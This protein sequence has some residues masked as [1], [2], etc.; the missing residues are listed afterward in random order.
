MPRRFLLLLLFCVGLAE[1]CFAQGNFI[2]SFHSFW[3]AAKSDSTAL[4]WLGSDEL[5][6]SRDSF[7]VKPGQVR[8]SLSMSQVLDPVQAKWNGQPLQQWLDYELDRARG[9]VVLLRPREGEGTLIVEYHFDPVAAPPRVQLHPMK[10]QAELQELAKEGT[11]P[12]AGGNSIEQTEELG[13]ASS[14][15]LSVSGSKTVSV[16]GGTNRDATV[17]QGL[18]LAV[19]GKLTENTFVRAQISDENLPITPEGNTEELKDID[20]VRIEIFGNGGRALLGDFQIDQPLGIYVPYQRKL[21][22]LWLHGRNSAGSATLLGGSPRGRRIELE[23]R[24]E[25]GVQGPYELLNGLRDSESYIIAGSERVWVDG[26]PQTRGENRDYTI[27]YIRGTITFTEL[28][29]IGPE[30]RIAA[31]FEVSA[32]GYSRTV[33]GAAAD[34]T[35]LGP[36]S[37]H[38]SWIRESDDPDRPIGGPLSQEDEKVLREA[39]DDPSKALGS[40]VT[41]VPP[42][43]EGTGDYVKKDENGVEY[44]VYAPG[45]STANYFLSFERVPENQGDY[46]QS[47]IT[48]QGKR[49]YEYRGPGKGD[50]VLGRRLSLPNRSEAL[51]IG[52]SLGQRGSENGFLSAEADFTRRDE[53]VL[54]FRDDENNDGLAWRFEGVSPWFLG[55]GENSG[56]RVRG[57]AEGI[58]PEFYQFGRIR[59]PFFYDAWNLQDTPRMQHEGRELFALNARGA[60]RQSEASLERLHRHG[61]FHGTRARWS[62]D[63][64]LFGPFNWRH[65]LA[66]MSH[67]GETGATGH[68]RN[69]SARLG[70]NL[71]RFEP[72]VRWNDERFD[73]G[74]SDQKRGYQSQE[75]GTG[76]LS[77]QRFATG[78][79]EYRRLLADSLAVEGTRWKFQ[80]DLREWRAAAE[81][82]QGA[83][84]WNL[85]GTWR[86]SDLDG[87][88][89]ESTRLGRI[90][91][92]YRPA[93]KLYGADLD[94]RAGN[95]RS[96]VIERTTIFVGEGQGDY[97]QEGNRIGRNLGDYNVVFSPSDSLIAATDVE[98]SAKV[99][100]EWRAAP[101]VG[102]ISFNG[103]Y[104]VSE[105]SQS[106]DVGGVLLLER[107]LLR[108]PDTTIFGEEHVRGDF[109]LLRH[110]RSTDLRLTF[111][112]T[113]QLDRRFSAT[114]ESSVR[115]ERSFRVDRDLTRGWSLRADGGNRQREK[116][117]D[118]TA[119]SFLNSYQVDDLYA[120][121]L[122]GYR[123]TART[124]TSLEGRGTRRNDG[125]SGISQTVLEF[126]P[127]ITTNFL[128]AR[129]TVDYRWADVRES[130]GDPLLRPFFF[131]RPGSNQ[132]FSTVAQWMLGKS[133][134]LTVRYQLRDEPQRKILQDLSVET[135]ARF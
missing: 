122:L 30:N 123:A 135:R 124:R 39:G 99:D 62:A 52:T 90:G 68:R 88:Q 61:S 63:G 75:W 80:Q 109:V 11:Q 102:G 40:G 44:Y 14:A 35:R 120:G 17:D 26:E 121:L 130:G 12:S 15:G 50:Y 41:P 13:A 58:A 28:R 38:A 6:T 106:D 42:G 46:A 21:Q 19:T 86:E 66:F 59:T 79:L 115:R 83:F 43:E 56:V 108:Q 34:S 98:L 126:V 91:L 107:S 47:E 53:N 114:P 29:P 32:T 51:V 16:Q 119:S 31:D 111:D 97:D 67:V 57:M 25:E 49:V 33:L 128:R 85:D 132:R 70:V 100:A 96:R 84:R 20:Q 55:S 133:L 1:P 23:I 112:Q 65:D 89:K 117:A 72:F 94:Y 116:V 37:F 24:G 104:K 22:G 110:V 73:D 77:H 131:E 8:F 92:G 64:T 69:R 74:P 48:N 129:W 71:G 118:P 78:R 127:S 82:L 101:L 113:T 81:G 9:T 125:F 60:E 93:G 87:G 2:P 105:R 3:V 54:S 45:D 5:A 7:A 10:R 134:S 36:A 27:D 76:V 103:L 95:D 4:H 18:H